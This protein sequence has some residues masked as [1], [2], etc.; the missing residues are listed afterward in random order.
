[1]GLTT[2]GVPGERAEVPWMMVMEKAPGV[3]VIEALLKKTAAVA[4][5]VLSIGTTG[6]PLMKMTIMVLQEAVSRI[7]GR[8]LSDKNLL[9]T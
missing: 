6:A 9:K 2:V 7:K 5:L 1:M 8:V 3:G 4:A